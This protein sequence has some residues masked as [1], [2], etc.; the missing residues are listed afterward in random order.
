MVAP[1][2][3][4]QEIEVTGYAERFRGRWQLYAIEARLLHGESGWP[5]RY[6]YR[7]ARRIVVAF[8][9]LMDALFGS[10]GTT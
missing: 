10:T 1:Q 5:R 7:S 4:G 2:F 8:D 9:E 3:L 6:R